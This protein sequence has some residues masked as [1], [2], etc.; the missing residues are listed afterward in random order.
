MEA[1]QSKS[2]YSV[3]ELDTLTGLLVTGFFP[4]ICLYLDKRLIRTSEKKVGIISKDTVLCAYVQEGFVKS[5][6]A[7]P[8][9]LFVYT[10]KSVMQGLISTKQMTMISHMHL[11]LHGIHRYE[12]IPMLAG[13]LSFILIYI[14]QKRDLFY[15]NWFILSFS[16]PRCSTGRGPY[17]SFGRMAG[18]PYKPTDLRLYVDYQDRAEEYSNEN[19][20]STGHSGHSG[21]NWAES[22]RHCAQYV[23]DEQ[24]SD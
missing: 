19:M 5:A 10:E 23:P 14:I 16:F 18:R 15:F 17:R 22:T 7:L 4:N 9:P 1:F 3:E 21:A 2:T 24:L 13:T 12:L 8:S 20:S 6:I 11:L